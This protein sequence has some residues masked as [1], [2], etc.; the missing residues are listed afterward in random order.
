MESPQREFTAV[1]KELRTKITWQHDKIIF[2]WSYIINTNLTHRL[3]PSFPDPKR[4]N[5]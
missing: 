1:L 2:F 4:F 3:K 5:S